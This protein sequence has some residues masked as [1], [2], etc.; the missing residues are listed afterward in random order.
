MSDISKS[1]STQKLK[2]LFEQKIKEANEPPVSKPS[3]HIPC[4]NASKCLSFSRERKNAYGHLILTML[5][6]NKQE[7][8]S[9]KDHLHPKKSKISLNSLF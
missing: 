6:K 9:Q 5:F 4:F 8:K 3:I 7:F 2:T 1:S